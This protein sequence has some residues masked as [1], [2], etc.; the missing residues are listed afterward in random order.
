MMHYA[1][2]GNM[3]HYLENHPD[4]NRFD[5]AYD[6]ASG[7]AYL[8][9]KGIVHANL[10]GAN[11]LIDRNVAL[12]ADFGISAII[13]GIRSDSDSEESLMDLSVSRTGGWMAP[14]CF[15]GEL[16]MKPSDVYSLG[17]TIWEAF[18]GEIPFSDVISFAYYHIIV[19]ECR[20][21]D[22][23][24]RLK[25]DHVWRMIT[26]LW[27]A[28]PAARPTVEEAQYMLAGYTTRLG[29]AP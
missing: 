4:A 21:P 15:K 22:R 1:P 29:L 20:R 14:E 5:L 2:N 3:Y 25:E 9:R 8:H 10:K 12:V 27:A 13:E 17:L 16:P 11:I 7:M 6:I 18:S 19:I 24:A 28:D 26:K 23:P